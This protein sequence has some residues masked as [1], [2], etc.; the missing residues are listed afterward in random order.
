MRKPMATARRIAL[1][2]REVRWRLT[3]AAI[4]ILFDVAEILS[5]GQ[6]QGADPRGPG[7]WF[8]STMVT[9]ELL[10]ASD[11]FREEPDASTARRV[12]ELLR[13]DARVA[14]RLR[15]IA[16]AD[17]EVRSGD[18]LGRAEVE[19]RARSVGTKVFLDLDL[20]VELFEHSG[21]PQAK[22]PAAQLSKH[23]LARSG[24]A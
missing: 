15:G 18:R 17:A 12:A 16:T 9:I 1:F 8:G 5:E 3:T 22:H 6:R 13:L 21:A 14:A 7:R 4:E 11:L 20:E 24:A 10:R 19:L 23:Q 2:E